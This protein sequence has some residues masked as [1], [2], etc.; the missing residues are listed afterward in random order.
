[1]KDH[2]HDLLITRKITYMKDDILNT[3]NITNMKYYIHERSHT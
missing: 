2:M 1:M 3:W